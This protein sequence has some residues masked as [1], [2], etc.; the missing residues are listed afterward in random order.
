MNDDKIDFIRDYFGHTHFTCYALPADASRR[1]YYRIILDDSNFSY[2]LMDSPVTGCNLEEFI[3]IDQFLSRRG[4][5]TPKIHEMDRKSGFLLLE[6]FGDLT[7]AKYLTQNTNHLEIYK[8]IIDVQNKLQNILPPKDLQIQSKQTFLESLN[9][10]VDY[11]IPF[12]MQ[13][14][15]SDDSKLEFFDIWSH[16]LDS[17]Y[18]IPYYPVITLRDYHAENLM[19][20]QD[21]NRN[22]IQS[23]G[24]LDFQD[25]AIGHNL[26]D[27]VSIMQDARCDVDTILANECLKYYFD[28]GIYKS[29]DIKIRYED[30]YLSYQILGAQRNSRI[31]G[32]FAKKAI[33]GNFEYI[34]YL[35]RVKGYLEYNLSHAKLYKLK[36]FT[37]KNLY[38]S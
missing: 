28:T 32:V 19:I 8:L 11:Y 30:V 34:T 22:D 5:S 29:G 7:V 16:T 20:L 31:L 15:V 37:D 18:D 38:I 27:I 33:E 24:L 13:R 36:G 9:L 12:V 6:D 3:F 35:N 17:L 23:I 2:I 14:Q 1:R 26:Y 10:Y 21:K 4:L 25:A